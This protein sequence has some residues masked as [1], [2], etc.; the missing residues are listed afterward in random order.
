MSFLVSKEKATA[1]SEVYKADKKQREFEFDLAERSGLWEPI[2][3]KAKCHTEHCAYSMSIE[4]SGEQSTGLMEQ[5]IYPGRPIYVSISKGKVQCLSGY[6]TNKT[7]K[8][9]VSVS[10]SMVKKMGQLEFDVKIGDKEDVPVKKFTM[11]NVM[12]LNFDIGELKESTAIDFCIKS[13]DEYFS[14]TVEQSANVAL[15]PVDTEIP[16]KNENSFMIYPEG[17]FILDV[18]ECTGEAMVILGK[19]NS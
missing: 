6:L 14:G 12:T 1:E 16:V 18:F 7:E 3:V 11:R 8:F 13:N 9:I 10:K 2:A 19:N 15:L 5:T 17:A 4:N